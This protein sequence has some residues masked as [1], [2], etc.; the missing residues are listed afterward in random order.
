[1][2]TRIPTLPGYMSTDT[3]ARFRAVCIEVHESI[4]A[5]GWT[6]TSDTGQLDIATATKPAAV[7]TYAGYRIYA[8]GDTLQASAPC[9]L[10][11]EFGTG[12]IDANCFGLRLTLSSGTNGAGTPTGNVSAAH[13]MGQGQTA[14]PV[15]SPCYFS[16]SPSRLTFLFWPNAYGSTVGF[17]VE[18]DRASNGDENGLG[19]G[20]VMVKYYSPNLVTQYIPQ[21]SA[22]AV[23][24]AE[25]SWL[26]AFSSSQTVQRGNNKVNVMP[27]RQVW[28]PLRNPMISLLCAPLTTHLNLVPIPR[29][30][31]G[32]SRNYL[33]HGMTG[34]NYKGATNLDMM[35]Y[36]LWE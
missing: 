17:C 28:G 13:A 23:P 7:N 30:L 19:V 4:V 24:L 12:Q 6:Q 1:M 18:R 31:Y 21:P 25:N 14:N 2:S 27:I 26:T 11:V 29:T 15:F 33:A 32:V 5:F 36:Q 3:D 34:T 10:K 9:Y 35:L 20:F 22:G 16:G 8:M